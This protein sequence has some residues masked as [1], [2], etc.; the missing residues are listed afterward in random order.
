MVRCAHTR[1]PSELGSSGTVGNKRSGR[2]RRQREAEFAA[3]WADL[4]HPRTTAAAEPGPVRPPRPTNASASPW[5]RICETCPC[6]WSHPSTSTR[7][8]D[9]W[10]SAA[11]CTPRRCCGTAWGAGRPAPPQPRPT[12]VSARQTNRP[13][14]RRFGLNQVRADQ[15]R[16]DSPRAQRRRDTTDPG[17]V[18][19]GAPR[20]LP[21]AERP[22]CWAVRRRRGGSTCV[23]AGT[24]LAV[25]VASRFTRGP[26]PGKRCAAMGT[27]GDGHVSFDAERVGVPGASVVFGA[28]FA[29]MTLNFADR[30]VV[31]AA[32][33]QREVEWWAPTRSSARWSRSCP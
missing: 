7:L 17:E 25:A 11:G 16:Q 32:F 13:R 27:A 26:S 28:A 1:P 4:E 6:L 33:P 21:R 5:T 2:R 31:V 29:L 3:L 10:G 22:L 30:H 14:E 9:W 18:R 23:I 20:S 24:A 8:F 15:I 19:P 12:P